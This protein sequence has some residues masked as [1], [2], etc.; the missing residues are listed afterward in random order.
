MET[1]IWFLIPEETQIKFRALAS[2]DFRPPGDE[3]K[4]VTMGES[5]TVG[6]AH[7]ES[8]EELEKEMRKKP[9]HR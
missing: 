8:I 7:L 1:P 5:G 4:H 9:R 3:F 6:E 2:A